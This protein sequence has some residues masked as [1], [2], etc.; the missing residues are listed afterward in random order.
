MNLT[1]W[2]VGL[3]TDITTL[4]Y[5]FLLTLLVNLIAFFFS[6]FLAALCSSS[7]VALA[8]FPILF[9]FLSNFAGFTIQLDNVQSFWVWAPYVSFPR[10]AYEGLVYVTFTQKKPEAYE[11]LLEY[12]SFSGW[13][14]IYSVYILLPYMLLV[15]LMVLWALQPPKSRIRRY[16]S[17]SMDPRLN[18]VSRSSSRASSMAM[19]M[20]SFANAKSSSIANR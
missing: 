6:Q 7:Q 14:P 10:W 17:K 19:G 20:D 5:M 16:A 18:R 4:A 9:M 12:F 3:P 15:N 13:N 8:L 2:L 1:Y 11:I